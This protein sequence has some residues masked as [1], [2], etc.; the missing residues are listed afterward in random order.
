MS[1]RL[2]STI[3]VDFSSSA[4]EQSLLIEADDRAKYS[5]RTQYLRVYPERTG[6]VWESSGQLVKLG[7]TV[8]EVEEILSFTNS[9]QIRLTYPKAYSVAISLLGKFHDVSGNITTTFLSFNGSTNTIDSSKIGFGVIK[10]TY[11]ARYTLYKFL[12]EGWGCPYE[13]DY[14]GPPSP[15]SIY[16]PFGA[17]VKK[18]IPYEDAIIVV[19]EASSGDFATISLQAPKCE[20]ELANISRNSGVGR[21][22]I[23]VDADGPAAI[24][25]YTEAGMPSTA[26]LEA[27]ALIR[28]YPDVEAKIEVTDGSLLTPQKGNYRVIHES[29][30]FKGVNGRNVKYPPQGRMGIKED[31]DIVDQWNRRVT[32]IFR[33]EGYTVKEVNWLNPSEYKGRPQNRIVQPGEIVATDIAGFVIKIAGLIKVTYTTTYRVYPYAF[34]TEIGINGRIVKFKNATIIATYTKPPALLN[35][36]QVGTL[37]LTAPSVEGSDSYAAPDNP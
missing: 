36:K 29:I 37:R 22:V 19:Y 26:V 18:Y 7:S 8:K 25:T 3:T 4:A 1:T 28:V 20:Y 31:S 34:D 9:K 5:L 15:Q 35:R 14:S 11:K 2:T 30:N 21:L 24:T 27:S 6:K 17:N 23:E 33:Q 32:V 16:N 10:V 13:T 12:Y